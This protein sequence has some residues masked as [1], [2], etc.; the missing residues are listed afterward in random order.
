MRWL[1]ARAHRKDLAVARAA[2][3]RE[4]IEGLKLGWQHIEWA[5]AEEDALRFTRR[6]TRQA[7]RLRVPAPP[8]LR[9]NELTDFWVMSDESGEIFLSEK[10][11]ARIRASIRQELDWR[12]RHRGH[13]ITWVVALTG[14]VGAATGLLAII[15][16]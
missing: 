10:G 12:V 4:R 9:G 11:V 2:G 13:W 6:L 3:D 16:H 7:K 14:L 15:R 8:M 1:D 5:Y